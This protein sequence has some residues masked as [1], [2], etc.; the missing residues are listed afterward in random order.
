MTDDGTGENYAERSARNRRE[1][2]RPPPLVMK[3]IR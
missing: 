2:Y 3:S 1:R